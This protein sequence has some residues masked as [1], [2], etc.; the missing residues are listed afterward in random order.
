MGRD[1]TAAGTGG[2]A[3]PYAAREAATCAAA[4][5][6]VDG[7]LP[8]GDRRGGELRPRVDNRRDR[9]GSGDCI[10]RVRRRGVAWHSGRFGRA[11]RELGEDSR[12]SSDSFYSRWQ[13]VPSRLQHTPRSLTRRRVV[14]NAGR[15]VSRLRG[16]RSEASGTRCRHWS[17]RGA[18]GPTRDW[19]HG[20]RARVFAIRRYT[21]LATA[22]CALLP[23][24]LIFGLP[25]SCACSSRR[26]L[27]AVT[28]RASS[29]SWAITVR[30][31]LVSRSPSPPDICNG[32][33]GRMASVGGA[34]SACVPAGLEVGAAGRRA[35]SSRASCSLWR[36]RC[37]S[38]SGAGAPSPA[39]RAAEPLWRPRRIDG[40]LVSRGS[41]RRT[42]GPASHAPQVASFCR[43]GDTVF[44]RHHG[45]TA[46]SRS[47]PMHWS[48]V[49]RKALRVRAGIESR[50]VLHA[51]V[52]YTTGCWPSAAGAALA[53]CPYVTVT[54][55]PAFGRARRRGIVGGNVDQFQ[56]AAGDLK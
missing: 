39:S 23:P 4:P 3:V 53:R 52:V 17:S 55:D 7:T 26:G 13:Q 25:I 38:A 40:V 31:R 36:G 33:S 16:R 49:R 11:V 24:L 5:R 8:D 27:S 21:L 48:L 42:S 12:E 22:G 29:S 19:E 14:G 34:A 1:P 43:A 6:S 44:R 51:D 41:G 47:H 54:A 37:I 20:E 30:R 46:G 56:L 28:P 18:H 10:A 35:P 9:R 2:M 50:A 15:G 45:R 32:A